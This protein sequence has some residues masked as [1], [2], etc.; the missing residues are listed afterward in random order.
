[1]HFLLIHLG[2]VGFHFGKF[3]NALVRAGN[4]SEFSLVAHE[5]HGVSSESVV[6]SDCCDTLMEISHIC[7]VPFFP[8][9]R[10]YTHHL[11]VSVIILEVNLGAQLHS[12]HSVTE[13]FGSISHIFV[14]NPL[15]DGL[16]S[17]LALGS[18]EIIVW[19]Q[20]DVSLHGIIESSHTV[21]WSRVQV[22]KGRSFG[23]NDM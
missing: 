16:T 11:P 5:S 3:E 1:M 4:G 22:V 21:I 7:D 20:I 23:N 2:V 9:F 8:V 18:K 10:H 17:L 14:R 15:V 19:D 6:Q 12:Y 13:L